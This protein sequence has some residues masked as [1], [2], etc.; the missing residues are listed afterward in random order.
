MH[1][2]NS[3]VTNNGVNDI[4][5]NETQQFSPARKAKD[6]LDSDCDEND[7]YQVEKMCLEDTKEKLELRRCAF[8]WKQK[9]HMG[10]KSE[11]T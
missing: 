4:I 3:A 11:I 5:L 2:E 6:V 1:P 9:I 7:I 10:L 8:E